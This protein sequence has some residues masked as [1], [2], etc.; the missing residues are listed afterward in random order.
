MKQTEISS[1]RLVM[2]VFAA[3]LAVATSAQAGPPLI[4]HA[5]DI[6]NAKSLPWSDNAWNL[7]G[8]ANYNLNHVVSDTLAIL[9]PSTPVI[10]RMETLRRAT[11]YARRDPVVAKALMTRL[12]QRATNAEV[13]G[14]PDALAWFDAGYLAECYKEWIEKGEPNPAANLDGYAWIEKAIRLR[15]QDPEME[16]GAALVKLGRPGSDCQL[17]AQKALAGAKQDPL[18]AR[19]L[20]SYFGG[21]RGEK[22]SDMLTSVKTAK[23]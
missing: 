12:Y 6:G 5:I 18:L 23:K 17:H 2:A 3:L 19:N 10:V 21:N 11:L 22:L 9:N 15:G 20:S 8:S 16:F 1:S 14:Q 4:C 13:K 7:T